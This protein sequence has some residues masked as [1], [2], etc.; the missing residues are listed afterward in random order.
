MRR[1]R[2]WVA[3]RDAVLTISGTVEHKI[4]AGDG[5]RAHVVSSRDGL[6]ASWVLHNRRAEARIEPVTVKQGDT[7][8]F[9]VDFREGLNNDEFAWAPTI[10]AAAGAGTPE[11]QWDAKAQFSPQPAAA[12]PPPDPWQ[13][14]AHV[15]LLSN[16]FLFV[17]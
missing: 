1:V 3:P 15:L 8:D 13:Q 16:E 4:E 6:L 17:D 9:V 12:L 11:E 10:K 2:R 7:I 5:V 14:Y